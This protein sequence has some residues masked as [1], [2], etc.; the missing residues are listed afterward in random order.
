MYSVFY[1]KRDAFEPSKPEAIMRALELDINGGKPEGNQYFDPEAH[2]FTA[3][4]KLRGKGVTKAP[5][6][7]EKRKQKQLAQKRA[8]RK[9]R[10]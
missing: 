6:Y 2:G 4:K 9:S 10:R 1:S 8:R 7:V 5:I 3:P